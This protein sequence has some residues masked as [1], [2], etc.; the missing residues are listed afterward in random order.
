MENKR[1]SYG[2]RALLAFLIALFIFLSGFFLSYTISYAK[3]QSVADTH[4]RIRQELIQ[5]EFERSLSNCDIFGSYPLLNEEL[6]NNG[7]I[8]GIL[9]ERFGKDDVRILEQKKEYSRLEEEHF[10]IVENYNLG[11]EKNYTTILFFYSNDKNL[12]MDAER[13]GFILGS[14]KNEN[15]SVMVYSFD[16]NLDVDAVNSLKSAYG[17]SEPNVLV[18]NG[19]TLLAGLE[20]ISQLQAYVT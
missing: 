5:I 18:I 20:D 6:E 14:F 15:P 13:M 1:N 19:K 10:Y 7:V 17:V 9:E 8:L 12:V 11:C 16:Y 3:Y 2:L 4:E